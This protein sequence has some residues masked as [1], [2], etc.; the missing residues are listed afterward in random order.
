MTQAQKDQIKIEFESLLL[1]YEVVFKTLV[2]TDSINEML[3][4]RLVDDIAAEAQ[5]RREE[6]YGILDSVVVTE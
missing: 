1:E 5:L 2:Y 6:F 3:G 4:K